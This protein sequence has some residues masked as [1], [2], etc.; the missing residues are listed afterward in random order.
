MKKGRFGQKTGG[1]WYDYVAGKRDAVPN[2][3]VVAMIEAHRKSLGIT[4]AKYQ[5]KKLCNDSLYRLM[6]KRLR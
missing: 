4:R 5:T 6:G 2:A 1:V 3:E